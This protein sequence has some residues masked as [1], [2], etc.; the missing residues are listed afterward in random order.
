[1]L[2]A[3]LVS[4][5]VRRS[6]LQLSNVRPFAL[7]WVWVRDAASVGC[8]EIREPTACVPAGQ[9]FY[10]EAVLRAAFVHTLCCLKL[11]QAQPSPAP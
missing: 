4:W 1:M 8:Q 11:M 9:R 6:A 2:P 3:V 5:V 7:W 10:L